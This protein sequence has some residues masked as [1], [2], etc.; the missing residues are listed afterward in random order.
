MAYAITGGFQNNAGG[1]SS[2]TAS[3]NGLA[4]DAQK[5]LYSNTSGY[6]ITLIDPNTGEPK[7]KS[8]DI[9]FSE[10]PSD[11]ISFTTSRVESTFSN[12]DSDSA[13]SN[14]STY[15]MY[16][17]S[18][19]QSMLKSAGYSQI[20][21]N[22]VPTWFTRN[23]KEFT[24]EGETFRE[25]FCPESALDALSGWRTALE[26]YT[27]A[28]DNL[29]SYHTDYGITD[30]AGESLGG[31]ARP[32]NVLRDNV[33]GSI[34]DVNKHVEK[35]TTDA[36]KAVKDCNDLNS[37]IELYKDTLTVFNNCYYEN[38]IDF[39]TFVTTLKTTISIA[40]GEKGSKALEECR[41]LESTLQLSYNTNNK[42]KFL[43]FIS[44]HFTLLSYADEKETESSGQTSS[45]ADLSAFYA[46]NTN[47]FDTSKYGW[48]LAIFSLE[49][50]GV[51]IFALNGESGQTMA[52]LFANGEAY[53]C[54][55]PVLFFK[56]QTT[57]NYP[58]TFLGTAKNYADFSMAVLASWDP[59]A[60]SGGNIFRGTNIVFFRGLI[61]AKN[62]SESANTVG[63]ERTPFLANDPYKGGNEIG[64]EL[65][66]Y[67]IYQE[68]R[69]RAE[70]AKALI[71]SNFGIGMQL[72]CVGRGS[73]SSSINTYDIDNNPKWDDNSESSDDKPD[74]S[75]DYKEENKNKTFQ[76]VKFYRVNLRN[77][78]Y[79]EW[80]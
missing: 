60:L 33:R 25:W 44:E 72:Y 53:A 29:N 59:V 17:N 71:D 21:S 26:N 38:K 37:A 80:S 78:N 16:V 40:Y 27:T 32:D 67:G 56:P 42:N 76:I 75:D 73:G 64:T 12:G 65:Q 24:G 55:E 70:T 48:A 14:I 63:K 22:P 8:I 54:V 20:D 5:T 11:T 18:S 34:V 43:D 62:E 52:E 30:G 3:G 41:D 46:A 58:Y 4:G 31:F 28:Q 35:L 39:T 77:G 19:I 74:E 49:N 13:K 47:T 57:K 10:P 66:T 7:S 9:L 61:L 69:Y 15:D 79:F 51:G 68:P 50:N 45:K 23:G 1:S 36:V 2:S 6:R